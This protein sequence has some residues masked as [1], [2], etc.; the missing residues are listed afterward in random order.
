MR[1]EC[2]SFEQTWISFT[3]RRIVPSLV[4]IDPVVLE[5]K[6]YENKKSLQQQLADNQTGIH[7][8]FTIS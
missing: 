1:I 5:K 8:I 6:M 7:Y 3:Q 2:S 4:D